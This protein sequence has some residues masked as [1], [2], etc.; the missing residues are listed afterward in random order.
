MRSLILE[1]SVVPRTGTGLRSL[2]LENSVVPRTG[3]GVEVI[4][5]RKQR[6]FKNRHRDE[7]IIDN[8][9][10]QEQV[11]GL[12]SLMSDNSVDPRTPKV[13]GS[14]LSQTTV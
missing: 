4:N 11:K 3:T 7:V 2:I 10:F 12:R 9:E 13:C 14:L 8:S 6:G 1:F 5:S